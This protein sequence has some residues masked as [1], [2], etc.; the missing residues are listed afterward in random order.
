MDLTNIICL[1]L[2]TL[3][4]HFSIADDS[5]SLL[6]AAKPSADVHSPLASD[7]GALDKRKWSNF[8]T[9]G[10]RGWMKFGTWGK[11]WH[12]PLSPWG[13]KWA[14]FATWGKRS[15]DGSEGQNLQDDQKRTWNQFIT[16]GKRNW[17]ALA[18]WG[19]RSSDD[20]TN[21]NTEEKR[22]WN[23]FA[24][25]GKRSDAEVEDTLMKLFD[26]NRMYMLPS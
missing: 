18:T 5:T 4:I 6:N 26:E 7:V 12:K 15:A 16:W 1:V 3:T 13:K 8:N 14:S 2:S 17:K 20:Q 23:K 10:K 11:R 25:W 9:W 24:S 21:W 19:K 22:R